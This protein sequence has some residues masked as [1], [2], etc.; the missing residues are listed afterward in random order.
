M[1]TPARIITALLLTLAVLASNA[2]ADSITLR[3]GATIPAGSPVTLA[4]VAMLTGDGA[5]A[6]AGVVI[7]DN[8]TDAANGRIWIEVTLDDVRAALRRAGIK[9]GPVALS[10]SKSILRLTGIAPETPAPQAAP[11]PEPTGIVVTPDGPATVRLRIAEALARLYAA[12]PAD[13][14]LLFDPRDDEFLDQLE[15]GRRIAVM[16]PTSAASSRMVVNVRIYTGDS[17]TDARSVTISLEIRRDVLILTSDVP[18]RTALTA[19]AVRVAPMWVQA[20]GDA[21]I[22]DPAEAAGAIARSDL[23][24]GAILR[25]ESVEPAILVERG[26]LV[27]VHCLSGGIALQMQARALKA[28]RKGDLIEVRRD[29]SKRNFTARVDGANRVIVDIDAAAPHAPE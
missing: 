21:L 8:A 28:G 23:K 9:L 19:D 6:H 7:L 11:E 14:R 22:T 12:E 5:L 25:A 3:P 17:M 4:D 24:A 15:H 13:L 1:T 16:T 2:R 29:G 10:G 27:R 26:A 18:R 20:G